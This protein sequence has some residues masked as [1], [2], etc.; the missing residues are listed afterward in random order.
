[1]GLEVRIRFRLERHSSF[2]YDGWYIDDVSIAE[3]SNVVDW[4]N[5]DFPDSTSTSVGFPTDSI[6][7]LVYEPDI[8]EAIGQGLGIVAELGCGPDGSEPSDAGWN[9]ILA[10]YD[11]DI[12][13]MDRYVATLTVNTEG[14]YDYAYRYRLEGQQTWAYADL[15][16]NDL[17]SGGTNG[18]SPSQAGHLAVIGEPRIYVSPAEFHIPLNV[19]STTSDTLTIRNEGDGALI[20]AILEAVG[21]QSLQTV[22]TTTKKIVDR[23]PLR[24][25]PIQK[26]LL[27]K[28]EQNPVSAAGT[29]DGNPSSQFTMVDVPWVTEYPA[30]G[31][32]SPG[33][34]AEVTVTFDANGLA[35]G[36][37]HAY[38]VITNNDPDSDVVV[39]ELPLS[40]N[41]LGSFSLLS[42]GDGETVDAS[43]VT[44]ESTTDPDPGDTVSYC[45][46]YST[47]ST[48]SVQ[49][50]MVCDL[51]ETTY[52][53]SVADSTTYYWKVKAY[54]QWGAYRWSDQ[55]WSFYFTVETFTPPYEGGS[56]LP[57]AFALSQNYPNPFNP[58][59]EVRYNLP[60]DCLMRLEVY[61]ILG[62]KVASLVEGEQKAGYKTARRDA[63]SVASGIYFY[64]L[65]AGGFVQ[66]RKM[67]LIR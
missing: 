35:G 57:Q 33:D 18:H 43:V 5:L 62:Q 25:F 11:S 45:V 46:Y 52:T 27:F 34:T 29:P 17:G 21:G 28:G 65:Q 53:L 32:I 24:A 56:T 63:S 6:Y 47:D 59:T 61:T 19:D 31:T 20:F 10:H 58:I 2:N 23:Q 55:V 54:D 3:P 38:L 9:W 36:A 64:R 1:V 51:S 66:T 7:G 30:S 39:V 41:P 26:Q 22:G 15:D 50:S 49:D 16:G 14:T 60:I 44:W 48:F 67:V 40:V 13:S 12:D 37:Y 4:C 42:P 8:T